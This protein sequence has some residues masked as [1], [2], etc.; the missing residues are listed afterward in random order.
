MLLGFL[1]L[2]RQSNE[3][4]ANAYLPDHCGSSRPTLLL[5][6]R[7]S[8]FREVTLI[9]FTCVSLFGAIFFPNLSAACPPAV[10]REASLAFSG[11]GV[12]SPLLCLIGLNKLEVLTV[13]QTLNL[14]GYVRKNPSAKAD[15]DG[16]YPPCVEALESPLVREAPEDI[17]RRR[18]LVARR[19]VAASTPLVR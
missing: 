18:E 19:V 12:L 14:Y 4:E 10:T 17:A 6:S 5:K 11:T 7:R 1:C 9:L 3:S 13:P 16:Y 15:A 2:G 8:P